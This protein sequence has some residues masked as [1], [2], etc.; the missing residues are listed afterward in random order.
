MQPGRFVLGR[1]VF[2][3]DGII[4]TC[5]NN[6]RLHY[7]QRVVVVSHSTREETLDNDILSPL[8]SLRLLSFSFSLDIY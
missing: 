2:A 4:R 3:L 5:N 6:S 7:Q 8:L 1:S